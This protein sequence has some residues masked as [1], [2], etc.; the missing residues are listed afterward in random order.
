MVEETF[1]DPQVSLSAS[2]FTGWHCLICG[3]I[4]DLIIL[5]NRRLHPAPQYSRARRDDGLRLNG[6]F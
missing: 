2:S 6:V 3:E 1:V 4:L 5:K